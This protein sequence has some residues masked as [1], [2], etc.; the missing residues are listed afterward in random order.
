VRENWYLPQLR[1]Q[2]FSILEKPLQFLAPS[3]RASLKKV[4][5]LRGIRD[6]IESL[7]QP[8]SDDSTLLTEEQL[9]DNIVQLRD[10]PKDPSRVP[11]TYLKPRP[12]IYGQK[13]AVNPYGS[14]VEG[15]LQRRQSAVEGCFD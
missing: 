13:S 3:D 9:L 11:T 7:H 8:P 15:G 4:E 5:P 6:T 14:E 12:E 10:K 1:F 2:E